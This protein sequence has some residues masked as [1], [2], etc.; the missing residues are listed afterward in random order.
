MLSVSS[1]FCVEVEVLSLDCVDALE[2]VVD[3]SL[4]FF[5][6][7]SPEFEL[8]EIVAIHRMIHS[9]I[10]NIFFI[11]SPF[12]IGKAFCSPRGRAAGLN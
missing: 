1:V 6:S 5:D 7:F 12:R 9:R 10:D 4:V 11:T 3:E 2:S 8:Q